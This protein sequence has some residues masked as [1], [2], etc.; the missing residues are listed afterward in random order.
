MT[1]PLDAI[2]IAA[3]AF[4]WLTLPVGL[5]VLIVGFT[6]RSWAK[7]YRPARAVFTTVH[8]HDAKLRWFGDGGAVHESVSPLTGPIPAVGDARTVWVHPSRP[9]A[10]RLDDPSHD[11]RALLTIGGI[12]TGVGVIALVLSSVLPLF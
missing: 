1:E 5:I 10:P 4:A 7:R 9:D 8:E 2:A 11:G 6:R 3:E 12:L